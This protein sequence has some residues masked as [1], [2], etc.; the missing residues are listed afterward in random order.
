MDIKR[1]RYAATIKVVGL[2]S[3]GA[4]A[5]N[6]LVGSELE[7]V[8]LVLIQANGVRSLAEYEADASIEIDEGVALLSETNGSLASAP[9]QVEGSEEEIREALEGA[10]MIVLIAGEGDE[11]EVGAAPLVGQI[12]KESGALIAGVIANQPDHES[13]AGTARTEVGVQALRE[14]VD[15]LVVVPDDTLLPGL[16]TALRG[17]K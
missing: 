15:M 7:G 16:F 8:D 5:V 9:H 11:P 17:R 4:E 1:P 10:D 6:R 3:G 13:P 2:G 12:A 14:A